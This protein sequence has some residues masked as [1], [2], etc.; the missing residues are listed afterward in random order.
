MC[1]RRQ[2]PRF[3]GSSGSSPRSSATMLGCAR[4]RRSRDRL[5]RSRAAWGRRASRRD[6]GVPSGPRAAR[7][8]GQIAMLV[9]GRTGG[10]RI[11]WHE[12]AATRRRAGFMTLT[13]RELSPC[14]PLSVAQCPS[15][16]HSTLLQHVAGDAPAS[17]AGD[18]GAATG[19]GLVFNPH[20]GFA[21]IRMM[22]LGV[23]TTY[24]WHLPHTWIGAMR[25]GKR[26]C[27]P[28]AADEEFACP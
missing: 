8:S 28:T 12:D 27:G 7:L 20:A 6:R 11:R 9:P 22:A 17:A 15:C 1:R 19:R 18:Q 16:C 25:S 24:E 21:L 3:A 13:H 2:N 26:I 5:R 23:Q 10:F 14:C 4:C